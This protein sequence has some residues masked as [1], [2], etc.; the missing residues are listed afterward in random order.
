MEGMALDVRIAV[1]GKLFDGGMQKR[2]HEPQRSNRPLL[3]APVTC[4]GAGKVA[5]ASHSRMIPPLRLPGAILA[6]NERE[7]LPNNAAKI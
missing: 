2:V 5:G 3:A 4:W 7:Q 1:S 6:F